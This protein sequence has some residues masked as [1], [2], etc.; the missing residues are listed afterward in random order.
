MRRAH[1]VPWAAV[2]LCRHHN[3]VKGH[4]NGGNSASMNYK[5]L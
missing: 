5:E 3:D 4:A 1:L 2:S